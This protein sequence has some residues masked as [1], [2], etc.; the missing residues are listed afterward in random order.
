MIA[1]QEF[2]EKFRY[3]LFCL[4]AVLAFFALIFA[5][6]SFAQRDNVDPF[7]GLNRS[8][9]DFN[10]SLDLAIIKPVSQTYDE[11][12]PPVA[13]R[14]VSN[15]FN[16]LDDVKVFVND[17]LQL[18]FRNA[19]HDSG[20][21]VLNTTVGVG[22]LIDV[23]TGMGLYKNDEDFGQTL[24]YWGVGPGPYVVLPLLG[25]RTV[26]DAIGYIPDV[27]LNPVFWINDTNTRYALNGLDTVETRA[28][29]LATEELITGDEYIFVRDAYLQRRE[30][31]VAD[32]EVYDEWDGI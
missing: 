16:N 19:M 24:G 32:G 9:N 2:Q 31:L 7:I 15:F 21:L 3:C 17:L 28:D 23:A 30:Y 20:R 11:F 10:T 14:G 29:F 6:V 5:P 26:R 1:V 27:F 25:S 8:V 12:L 22:G 18:K 13:K 4:S